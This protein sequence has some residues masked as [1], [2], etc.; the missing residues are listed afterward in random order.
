MPDHLM[1][2]EEGAWGQWTTPTSAMPVR[3]ANLQGQQPLMNTEET[4]GGRGMLPGAI[5]EVGAGGPIACN[6]HPILLP[7]LI[8]S[9]FG[10]R[11]TAGAG[12]GYRN[13]LLPDDEVAFESFS[14]QQRYK[15]NLA[16]NIKGAKMSSMTIAAA[17]RQFAQFTSEW[18]A[19]DIALAG[20][21]WSDDTASAAVVDPP[22]YLAAMPAPFKFYEGVMR[23]GGT[24]SNVGN[25]LVVAGGVAMNDFDNIEVAFTFNQSADAYGVNLGDRTVQSI[26]EGAREIAVRFAPNFAVA[27]S[28]YWAAWKA[29]E[30][31]VVELYFAG[32]EYDGV[33]NKNYEMKITLPYVQY[34]AAPL[35]E[36]SRN[37]GLR[38]MSVEGAGKVDPTLLVDSGFVIQGT[39]DLS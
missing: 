5:G 19:K 25:E 13:A 37:Y 28:A 17:T 8:R 7:V 26:D 10:S 3:S 18:V 31:A 1:F 35:P 38:R 39:E 16:L 34:S 30:P 22:P 27:S 24:V 4:G 36:V 11:T 20:G 2:A 32:V 23:L 21:T 29:G 15:T 6:L 14:F 33:G 12:T 9:A